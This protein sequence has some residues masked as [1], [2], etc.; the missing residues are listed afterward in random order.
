MERREQFEQLLKRIYYD[1]KGEGSYGSVAKLY[2]R[3]KEESS[4]LKLNDVKEFLAAQPAY[5]LHKPYRK[6]FGRN[7]TLAN[8]IDYQWQADLADLNQYAKY[9]DGVRYLM[10]VID[11][12]SRYAWVVPVRDKSAKLMHNAFVQLLKEST[13]RKPKHLQTDK[14]KEFFNKEVRNLLE[15]KRIKHFATHSDHKAALVER[16]NRTLKMRM[17]RY[18]RAHNTFR[19]IEV[20]KQLVDGYNANVHRALGIPPKDVNAQN[21]NRL[22]QHLYGKHLA[23]APKMHKPIAEGTTVRLSKLKRTFEKGDM[24][25]WTEEVFRVVR[26]SHAPGGHGTYKVADW[27]GEPIEGQFYEHEVQKVVPSDLFVIDHIVKRRT[28]G[29]RKEVLVK[30]RGWPDKFNQWL[31]ESDLVQL[32]QNE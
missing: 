4:A 10:T 1:P 32:R 2:K 23:R 28:V 24:P 6:R 9:N 26:K 25:N 15:Q 20:L 27:D 17:A 8:G 11:V 21:E 14:G 7:P 3:A 30:W 13:P 16:L 29:K 31:K 22:W 18:F 12:F 5:T 19:Y